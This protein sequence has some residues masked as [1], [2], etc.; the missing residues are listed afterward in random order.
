MYSFSKEV[1]CLT[2]SRLLQEDSQLLPCCLLRGE[3]VKP[4]QANWICHEKNVVAWPQPCI[5]R[6]IPLFV[7]LLGLTHDFI[8]IVFLWN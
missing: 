1:T 5:P 8:S 6:T 4:I 3:P 2:S 7:A